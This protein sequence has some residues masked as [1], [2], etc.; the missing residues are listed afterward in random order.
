MKPPAEVVW[1]SGASSG[2]G[3]ALA[4]S[5]AKRGAVLV[6][7]ARRLK[8]LKAVAVECLQAGAKAAWAGRLDVASQASVKSFVKQGLKASGQRADLLI[9]NA[10][11]H[12][13]GKIDELTE[14]N[15]DKA[16]KINMKGPIWMVQSLLP[17]LKKARGGI[18]QISS[19]HA[20][21][22]MA[23]AGGY[24]ASKAAL[25]RITESLRDELAIHQVRVMTVHPGVIATDLR[26]HA[27]VEGPEPQGKL[28][29]P[30]A[31][32]L[33]ADRIIKAY[34]KGQARL[35]VAPWPV[36]F[37]YRVINWL[38]P[39]LVDAKM[40]SVDARKP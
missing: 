37:F 30:L 16:F 19:C 25:D 27:L 14:A 22:G 28:P 10:G 11:L 6:L 23:G 15:L 24:S 21:R 7:G 29:M 38:M 31:A 5:L 39:G 4:L 40:K 18:I 2:L 17:A 33:V 13:F 12:L 35:F 3:R 1:I 36:R 26:K 9:N 34:D 32:S 8:E 20:F